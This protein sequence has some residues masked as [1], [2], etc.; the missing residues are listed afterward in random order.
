MSTN[1]CPEISENTLHEHLNQPYRLSMNMSQQIYHGRCNGSEQNGFTWLFFFFEVCWRKLIFRTLSFLA[2]VFLSSNAFM[3]YVMP[4]MFI[5]NGIVWAL[6]GLR[7]L[8]KY[9]VTCFLHTVFK[10]KLN[11]VSSFSGKF[12]VWVC[13]FLAQL[14][15]VHSPGYKTPFKRNIWG[16]IHWTPVPLN[17][18]RYNSAHFSVK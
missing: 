10:L 5:S 1:V 12:L 8:E 15:T 18:Y 11:P 2:L 7:D 14:T 3:I 16:Y 6:P 13:F 17:I 4:L 9:M